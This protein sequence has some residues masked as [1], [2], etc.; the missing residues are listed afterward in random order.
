[1][2]ALGKQTASSLKPEGLAVGTVSQNNLIVSGKLALFYS[3]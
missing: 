2:G 1:M 3:L